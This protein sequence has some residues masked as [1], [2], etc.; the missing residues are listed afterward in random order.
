MKAEVNKTVEVVLRLSE[1]EAKCLR[2]IVRCVL[3]EEG[4]IQRNS[5]SAQSEDLIDDM[6][7][8]LFHVLDNALRKEGLR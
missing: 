6:D 2:E 3:I 1:A 7:S 8:L 4:Q 5:N